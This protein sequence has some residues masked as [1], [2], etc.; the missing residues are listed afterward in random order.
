MTGQ[1]ILSQKFPKRLRGFRSK[2]V[3]DYLRVIADEMD[4]LISENHRLAEKC[5]GL[6]THRKSVQEMEALL[7]RNLQAAADLYDKTNSGAEDLIEES[8]AA[9]KEN[10]EQAARESARLRSE[11]MEDVQRIREGISS[12]EK[13][14]ERSITAM[15]E[16]LNAQYRFLEQEA[17]HLGF[18]ISRLRAAGGNKFV[19]PVRKT[20]RSEEFMKV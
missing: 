14:R 6:E 16:A 9:A 8:K 2:D 10:L 19:R 5:A 20:V 7:K 13:T 15:L 12:L 4:A 3:N 1:D 18:N 11:A 17:E